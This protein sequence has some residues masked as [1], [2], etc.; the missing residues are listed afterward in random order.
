MSYDFAVWY[1]SR[2]ITCQEAEQIYGRLCDED[3]TAVEPNPRIADFLADLTARYPEIDNCDDEDLDECPWSNAFDRSEGHVIICMCFSRTTEVLPF[4]EELASEHGLVYFDPQTLVVLY[5]PQIAAIPHF[6][7]SLEDGTVI[8]N[9]T[10]DSI[11][12]ALSSLD[13]DENSF[14]ILERTELTYI[15]TG[16]QPNDEYVIEY[17]EGSLREH[18][19]TFTTDLHCVIDVFQSYAAGNDSWKQVC[20]WERVDL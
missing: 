6:R 16:R 14:A 11:A 20:E 13:K 2:P 1:A 9:P 19:Q 3:L 8:D 15:Q 5:P 4:V 10:P 12:T 17:Q 18:F 7:I